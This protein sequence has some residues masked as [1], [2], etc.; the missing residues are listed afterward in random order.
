MYKM[1]EV[2]PG[3]TLNWTSWYVP[4]GIEFY[5]D[6]GRRLVRERRKMP[7]YARSNR[8]YLKQLITFII[9][10][11]TCQRQTSKLSSEGAGLCLS[12]I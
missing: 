7:V 5:L 1:L 9:L 8:A 3:D 4:R 11:R 10:Y 12:V 6:P 2:E